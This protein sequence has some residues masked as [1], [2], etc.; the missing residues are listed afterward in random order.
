MLK[1]LSRNSYYLLTKPKTTI[2]FI[3]RPQAIFSSL[4]LML[5]WKEQ[6]WLRCVAGGSCLKREPVQQEL[7]KDPHNR[8]SEWPHLVYS[9]D[10][11]KAAHTVTAQPA[12]EVSDLEPQQCPHS[13]KTLPQCLLR[14][15]LSQGFTSPCLIVAMKCIDKTET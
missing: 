13:S 2:Y 8:T 9:K 12:V 3:G 5:I 7:E 11:E 1:Y 10:G 14:L 6:S 4:L 15:Q